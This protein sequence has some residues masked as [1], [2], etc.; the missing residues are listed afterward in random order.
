MTRPVGGRIGDDY[1]GR[2]N[3]EACM[4]IAKHADRGV[5]VESED[6]TIVDPAVHQVVFENEHVRV[7]DACHAR[8]E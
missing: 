5:R 2:L 7:I 1:E 6:S 8:M 3:E 4:T